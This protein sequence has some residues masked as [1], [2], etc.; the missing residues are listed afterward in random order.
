MGPR[1]LVVE[2]DRSWRQLL[3][4]LLGDM[5]LQVDT[6][7]SLEAAVA[8]LR[9]APHRVAVV[10][11]AL[12]EADHTNQDGLRVLEAAR[13]HD[14]GC[15]TVMLT[16][17]ATVDLAVQALSA[18]GAFTL[19]RK[20]AF[21]RAEFREVIGRALAAAPP[22]L[23]PQGL[24][25]AA[26]EGAR[27]LA[28]VVEDDAGWRGILAELLADA[29][30]QT[31]LCSGYGEAL[32]RLR[33]GR[34]DLAVVDL[35][36]EGTG[37]AN[38]ARRDL[39]GGRPLDGYRLLA[40]TRATGIPTVVVTGIAT[41]GE[42]ERAYAEYGAHACLEKRTFDRRAFLEAVAEAEAQ[43]QPGALADLTP[44][45]R[46]AL[47]LLAQGKSN[48]EIADAMVITPN[49]VKRHLKAIFA[50][51]GVHTRAA[52]AAKAVDAGLRAAAPDDGRGGDS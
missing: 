37:P 13:R 5:G 45:E 34:F 25:P 2:D 22:D 33:R 42:I 18:Y 47:E 35:S 41:P 26:A 11:L 31:R 24:A 48:R 28:L 29:G 4:E 30:Y 12:G 17:Y 46:D 10:D 43:R 16:G 3:G 39:G 40:S 8:A 9:R 38:A 32:G 50:K 36:L 27:R 14:P 20:E 7:E 19:L 6:A 1:A 23:R 52:A 49:T 21:R 15:A 44:R 51:L